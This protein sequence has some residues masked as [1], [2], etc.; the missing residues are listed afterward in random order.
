M[1]EDGMTESLVDWDYWLN[2]WPEAPVACT[3]ANAADGYPRALTPISQD[4]ILTYEE[5]AVRRF[6]FHGLG[7]LRPEQVPEPFMNAFYGLVY[8]NADHMGIMGAVT[9]GS[10]RQAMYQQFFGL[11]ADPAYVAPKLSVKAQLAQGATGLR[12]LPR[13]LR[14]AKGTAAEIERQSARVVSARPSGD[15]AALSERELGDWLRRLDDLQ[16]DCW[17]T[18]MTGAVLAS[19]SFEVVRK[20]LAAQAGDSNG[21]LTNRLHVGLGG[22]ESAESGR[23]VRKLAAVV[24]KEGAGAALEEADPVAALRAASPVAAAELDLVIDRFGHRA[25]AELELSNPSFRENP[26]QLLD[27]VRLEL[28]REEQGEQSGKIRQEAE[29]ELVRRLGPV[30]LR[31]V[32]PLLRRSQH[33]MALRENGKIPAVRLFDEIRRL[34]AVAGPRLFARGVLPSPERV[35]YLRHTELHAVLAG[36]EGP[37]TAEIERRHQGHQQCLALDLPELV[38]VGPGGMRPLDDGFILDRGLLPPEKVE[39]GTTRL[40]G[41]AAAPGTL[42]G[43]ARVLVD[44]YG[45][46]DAGDILFARTVDPGW[47]PI[48]ACAGALVLD[49][50]GVLSHGAVVARELG[51]PCV[52][53]VKVGTEMAVSGSTVTVDGSAGEVRLDD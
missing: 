2:T 49:I 50:G 1:A 25:P 10:S 24:R 11:D 42:T 45:D 37:G 47:A 13:M 5:A 9:P 18:L 17:S 28:G 34:L 4:L 43:T 53:N 35:F 32:T 20:V 41:I 46:F 44:P 15:L 23:S 22:N 14:L 19:A 8:L 26:R 33:Q 40:H 48:L 21:D 51:I 30:K 3:R 39:A 7:V 29:A 52:V 38:E 12:V 27:I 36:G 31:A 16:V 6:Y